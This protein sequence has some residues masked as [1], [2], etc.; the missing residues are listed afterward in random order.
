MDDGTRRAY[1]ENLIAFYF[2][3]QKDNISMRDLFETYY[4]GDD[5]EIIYNKILDHIQNILS[6]GYTINEVTDRAIKVAQT[7]TTDSLE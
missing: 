4:I 3:N 1:A 5:K 6:M 2:N 7:P